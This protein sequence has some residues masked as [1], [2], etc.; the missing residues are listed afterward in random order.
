MFSSINSQLTEVIQ[1]HKGVFVFHIRSL[2]RGSLG[3]EGCPQESRVFCFLGP[4]SL[5]VLFGL[6][7]AAELY[8]NVVS[9]FQAKEE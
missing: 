8:L 9:M 3:S 6:M 1:A 2:Q 5:T 4:P 7:E